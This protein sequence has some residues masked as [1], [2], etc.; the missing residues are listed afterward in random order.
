MGVH[1]D[2][3]H[4]AE[5]LDRQ[6]GIGHVHP[7]D[8]DPRFNRTIIICT[9]ASEMLAGSA[10]AWETC[11]DNPALLIYSHARLR[12]DCNCTARSFG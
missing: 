8:S 3:E 4:L 5:V 1:V 6:L 10:P 7:V 12:A 11:S 9:A 2:V